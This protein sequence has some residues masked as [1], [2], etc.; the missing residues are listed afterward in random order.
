[1]KYFKK[2]MKVI[3]L[4][5]LLFLSFNSYYIFLLNVNRLQ[6]L[7]YLDFLISISLFIYF[8][9]DYYYFMKR[10][11]DTQELLQSK[12]LIYQEIKKIENLDIIEHDISILQE[13]LQNQIALNSDLQDYIAKWC[14]EI[15]IPLSASLLLNE[16]N[17]NIKLKKTLKEQLERIKQHLNNVLLGCKIQSNIY[18]FKISS[19]Y[20]M[21]CVKT[22]L[23][24]NQFFLIYNHFNI[25]IQVQELK[26]YTDKEWLVYIL[27][28]LINNAI[29]YKS[30]DPILKIWSNENNDTTQL[31]IED[32]GEGIKDIDIRRVFEKGFTGSNHHNGQYKS[33]G[34]GLYIVKMI[35][36]KLEH[37]IEIESEYGKYTRVTLTFKDHREY[38]N[39][40]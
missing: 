11:N 24:N 15:K 17:E 26:I 33:T 21:D 28:Q 5:I 1:M 3:I 7:L 18:D 10:Y 37:H 2:N 6:Y 8:S 13:Q 23:H 36:D 20:L 16:K 25:D 29:K 32:N 35:V 12:H 40:T 14:H 19:Q 31:I 9:I 27:D 4:C 38:F 30:H 22:S 39:I 34:M